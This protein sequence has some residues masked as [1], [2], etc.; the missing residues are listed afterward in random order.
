MLTTRQHT[1]NTRLVARV[2]QQKY[3]VNYE[4][5]YATVARIESLRT[6]IAPVA[7]KGLQMGFID[8]SSAFLNGK[9]DEEVY[10]EPPKGV[11]RDKTE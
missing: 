6:L 5:T 1:S 2:F 10:L 7:V 11:E 8:V 4:E 9:L 3:A